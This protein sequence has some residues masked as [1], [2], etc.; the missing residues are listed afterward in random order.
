MK[1]IICLLILL[2]S[3][4]GCT[5]ILPNST[6]KTTDPE[7]RY[8]DLI[9][10]INEHDNFLSASNN[11]NIE[12]EMSKISD[13]YRFYVTIDEARNAMYDIEAMAIEKGVDYGSTMAANVGIFDEKEY[14]MV[15]YQSN[16]TQ[17]FM[18]GIVMSGLTQNKETTLYIL[19][20][21]KRE[22]RTTTNREIF[23]LDVAYGD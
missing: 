21:W 6:K 1:K 4:S 13:G 20:Q 11:Y 15:P 14:N 3:L 10:I 17:G 7:D 16:P 2:I 8:K 12:V 9:E 22:D 18:K 19:V 5:N 23:K